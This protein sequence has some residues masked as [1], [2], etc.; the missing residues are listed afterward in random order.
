[1]GKTDKTDEE[2]I[3][4]WTDT[5]TFK[6]DV[7]IPNK[8]L[9]EK[10]VGDILVES[11]SG[12]MKYTYDG[13]VFKTYGKIEK[14]ISEKFATS[15]SPLAAEVVAAK[16]KTD[17]DDDKGDDESEESE[18]SEEPKKSPA[19]RGPGRPKKETKKRGPKENK[20]KKT[21][22]ESTEL[23]KGKGIP[24]LTTKQRTDLK[25]LT[26]A[27]DAESSKMEKT[28]SVR[29]LD[30]LK[31]T[32]NQLLTTTNQ[33]GDEKVEKERV[34]GELKLH[35]MQMQMF[36][37]LAMS[38]QMNSGNVSAFMQMAG[39]FYIYKYMQSMLLQFLI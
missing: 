31:S 4:H 8:E 18:E 3:V 36:A 32:N 21:R 35:Q 20:A 29:M 5:L 26:A 28:M 10:I 37:A 14:F 11:V 6:L 7:L 39:M 38:G 12:A 24:V 19:K 25:M 34:I 27:T 1:M 15:L 9:V 33:L 16:A 13:R 22:N 2:R 30:D 17:E 23:G